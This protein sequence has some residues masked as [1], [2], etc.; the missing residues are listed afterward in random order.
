MFIFEL[1]D[2]ISE[3]TRDNYLQCSKKITILG[4]NQTS[5]V[6]TIDSDSFEILRAVYTNDV[7]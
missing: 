7:K 5:N 3:M 4:G 2:D 1:L 6:Y